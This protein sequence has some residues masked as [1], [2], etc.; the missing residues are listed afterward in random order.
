M[1]FKKIFNEAK[2]KKIWLLGEPG[3]NIEDIF[4]VVYDPKVIQKIQKEKYLK[5]MIITIDA[6]ELTMKD[7]DEFI[8]RNTFTND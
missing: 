5:D 6:S 8:E 4:H 7:V 1:E 2:G 3:G